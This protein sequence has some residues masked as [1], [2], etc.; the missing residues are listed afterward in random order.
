MSI[1][2][3]QM[4][5]REIEAKSIIRKY[6]RIDS[7]FLSCYAMNL[8]RGCVHDCTYCDGRAEKYYV[9]GE[10]GEDV[11][12]KINAVQILKR[13]LDPARK[14]KPFKKCYFML[15]GGVGDSY[16]PVEKKYELTRKILEL[17]YEFGHPVSALTK[18][19]LIAR[20]I[21]LFKKI[22]LRAGAV[23]SFSFSSVDEDASRLLEPGVPPPQERLEVLAMIKKQGIPA[24]MF[25]M[26]VVPFI[27]DTDEQMEKSVRAAKEY[28]LDFIIFGNM[29]LKDGKQK[30]YFYK[31]IRPVFPSLEPAYEG[32]YR[33][34]KWGAPADS[35]TTGVHKRFFKIAKKYRIPL[36]MPYRLFK[37]ILSENDKVI[38]LLDHI[39][40]YLKLEGQRS[41]F[42]Y[43]GYLLSKIKESLQT[44]KKKIDALKVNKTVRDVIHE[45]LDTGTSR[46][47]EKLSGFWMQPDK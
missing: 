5:V 3:I 15:G 46:L 25:L 44:S 4:S 38:V 22:H 21:D 41:S 1:L 35:Y 42:G 32:I 40:Y 9:E 26:P 18:S 11:S 28:N 45:I 29:T 33:G 47:Y 6:K 19:T 30:L 43:A 31:K 27:T 24:G 8:Y 14:R 23:I 12:V 17:L 7:W 13:E 2:S 16:Q 10:F 36:R 39:D 37:H 20:D 34:S